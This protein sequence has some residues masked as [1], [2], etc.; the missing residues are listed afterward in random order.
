MNI[1]DFNKY[2]DLAY[3]RLE[4][5]VTYK[6]NKYSHEVLTMIITDRKNDRVSE[7]REELLAAKQATLNGVT[8]KLTDFRYQWILDK[9]NDFIMIVCKLVKVNGKEGVV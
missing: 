7:L 9:R 8:Y 1:I 2:E 5:P 4:E 3:C 6:G